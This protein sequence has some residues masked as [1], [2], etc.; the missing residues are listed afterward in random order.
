MRGVDETKYEFDRFTFEPVDG[1]LTDRDT[2]RSARLRPQA[3]RLLVA[4]L[5]RAGELV[6]RETLAGAVWRDERV[7]DFEAGLAALLRELRGVLAELDGDAGLIETLPRRGVRLNASAR[8]AA[9]AG[10]DATGTRRWLGLAG[11]SALV[12][13]ALIVAGLVVRGGWQDRQAAATWSLALL[14][15]ESPDGSSATTGIVLADTLL[16]EL[17]QA[18][19][20]SLELI[21]RAG[22]RPYAGRDDVARAVAAD[23]GVDLLLE[24][25]FRAGPDGWRVDV[26][27][28]ATPPGRV[29]WSESQSGGESELPVADVA[30]RLVERLRRDWPALRD[31][32][33]DR[34]ALGLLHGNFRSISGAFH[35]PGE[36]GPACWAPLQTSR[37]T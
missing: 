7:V 33:G 30:G 8:C 34:R 11:L 13:A 6:D 12:A 26:R 18:D 4:L 1:T 24:G 3:A 27:L 19:L 5:D 14:P 25:S 28:L 32:L 21:G 15:L 23:L 35:G 17:W 36:P 20:E 10:P 31:K 16:A 2:G 22:M 37:S 9:R 29:V